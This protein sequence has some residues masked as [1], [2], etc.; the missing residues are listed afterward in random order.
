MKYI[1]K[2]ETIELG[3]KIN[4]VWKDNPF[5]LV[6]AGTGV[7]KTFSTIQAIGQNNFLKNAHIITIAPKSKILDQSW[8]ASVDAYNEA[9]N[10]SL[11]ID[12]YTYDYISN[13]DDDLYNHIKEIL[14]QKK[15]IILT[16]DEAHMIK[17]AT[18][19]RTKHIIKL[20]KQ[21]FI[22][23]VIGLSA[24]PYS[25]SYMDVITYLILNNVYKNKTAF[26]NDQVKFFTD[27]HSPIVKNESGEIDRT[28]FKHPEFI[29]QQLSKIIVDIDAEHLLPDA[30]LIDIKFDLNTDKNIKYIDKEFSE[31]GDENTKPRTQ[32]GNYNAILSYYRQ[33][34]YDSKIQAINIQRRMITTTIQRA[35]AMVDILY[36]I[37]YSNDPH[38]VLIFYQNN[39]ELE[40]ITKI[41]N[42][43]LPKA[44]IHIVNGKKKELEDVTSPDTIILIQY[45]AGGAAIE[46]KN[47]YSSIYFMP[48]YSYDTYKQTKG[49]NRRAHMTHPITYYRLIANNTL[50]EVMWYDIIEQKK[51]FTDLTLDLILSLQ[52]T[53]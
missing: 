46:F 25:N 8:V 40:T 47:A 6:T 24:T 53:P 7:G 10:T 31:F 17:N 1:D 51:S 45:K 11:S 14:S 37:R 52:N 35:K 16:I 22:S 20:A 3:N 42:K 13:H 39:I 9:K 28:L 29:E 27:K 41:I 15:P 2:P 48:T 21:P 30:K 33:G 34:F 49:R 26:I 32:R 4:D 50:D 23:R 18:S 43:A 44:I 36:K 38:P 5:A 19:I 12:V